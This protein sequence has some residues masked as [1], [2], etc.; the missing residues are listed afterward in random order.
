MK[1]IKII[2][3]GDLHYPQYKDTVVGDLKDDS[4]PTGLS[5]VVTPNQLQ[6]VMRKI[7]KIS[8]D[9][10]I[11]GI[12]FCGDMTTYGNHTEYEKCITYLNKS[13]E[14]GDQR[15]WPNESLHVVPGNHDVN[16]QLCDPKGIELYNKFIPLE[17]YW[18]NIG[19]DDIIP[20]QQIRSSVINSAGNSVNIFS[21]NSCIGCG[22]KRHLPEKIRTK[23]LK[24]FKEHSK[25]VPGKDVFELFGEQLDTPAFTNEDVGS[26]VD[27]IE[28]L[29][30]ESIPLVL[31]H[32]NVLSQ[33]IPRLEIYT[34]LINS[35]LFRSRLASC[36]RPII[37][38]HGHIHDDS[39]EQVIDHKYPLSKI[40]FVSAP[41]L[42]N[43][44]NIIEV[45]FARNKLPVGCIIHKYKSRSSGSIDNTE[46]IRIPLLDEKKLPVFSDDK[47][48][49]LLKLCGGEYKRFDELRKNIHNDLGIN[50]NKNSLRDLI[51][52]AEWLNLIQVNDRKEKPKYWKIRRLEP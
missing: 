23:L 14:V 20:I 9:E 17:K 40:V 43:G 6:L 12:I 11:S 27:E 30:D 52:E 50:I 15:K 16:R 35:G 7:S 24:L 3:V 8:D 2:Q 38:C 19:R 10:D 46:S 21:L 44:F 39:V 32:H 29:D 31:A 33:A 34:E 1:S 47:L 25:G 37:Y 36:S 49:S 28:R 41:L 5:S 4:V 42:K 26:L 51:L 13:I 45:E 22:E 18:S 48:S